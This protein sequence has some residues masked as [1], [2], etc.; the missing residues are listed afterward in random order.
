MVFGDIALVA[1]FISIRLS[2]LSGGTQ[3]CLL[4]AHQ[5]C[6]SLLAVASFPEFSCYLHPKRPGAF[7]WAPEVST[8]WEIH[9]TPLP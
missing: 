2:P 9:P 5:G 1:S 8:T 6:F 7:L 3:S 4:S